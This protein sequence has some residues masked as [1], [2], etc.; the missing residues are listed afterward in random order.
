MFSGI[1]E[2]AAR[3]VSLTRSG[4]GGRLV[5]DSGLDHADTGTGDSIAIEGVCLTV[6]AVQGSRLEFDLAEETIRRSTLGELHSGVR[7]N[8]ERS[9]RLGER[10][11]G[12]LVCGHID[13]VLTLEARRPEGS[14]TAYVW[15]FPVELRGFVAPKGSVAVAGVSLT[16]G[17]VGE[18]IFSTYV[19]PHT[20]AV[21]TLAER[22]PG[23]RVNFEVDVLARYVQSLLQA[24]GENIAAA[25]ITPEFLRRHGFAA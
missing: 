14:S 24:G 15:R 25:G 11:H 20:A 21:T 18:A 3:V 22:R 10:L 19:V 13:G 2:E 9:L 23:D 7:V 6:V 4:S 8:L 12:H 17:E 16:V 5:V 1:V